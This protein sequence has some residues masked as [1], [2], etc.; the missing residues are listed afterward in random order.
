MVASSFR[1]RIQ[2]PEPFFILEAM[3]LRLLLTAAIIF[4]A[5]TCLAEGPD[6]APLEAW[7]TAVLHGDSAVVKALYSSTPSA[8]I[9]VDS[10]EVGADADAAFWTG[11]KARKID[12]NIA[13]STSPQPG[14]QQIVFQAAIR[15]AGPGRTLYVSE[16]QLW[17][18]QGSG[19]K[20]IAVKR[21][22]AT[23]L[24]QPLSVDAKIYPVSDAHEEIRAALA[25]AAKSGKRVFVVFGAD[26]C[27]DCHVLDK[28]FKRQDIAALLNPNYELVHIDVGRGEK[29]QDLMNQYQVPMKRGIPA[30]AAVAMNPPDLGLH[31][32][33]IPLLAKRFQEHFLAEGLM[34][35]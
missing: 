5:A 8:R 13:Q 9:D 11:L 18:Q 17:Q 3:R 22:D 12:L 33:R 10:T 26:W 28:A 19:W 20:L 7:K 1:T 31:E 32:V 35:S 2:E 16:G 29:N 23:R 6:F 27:F 14:V 25:R 21:T 4:T 24:E 15:P 30:I 34:I